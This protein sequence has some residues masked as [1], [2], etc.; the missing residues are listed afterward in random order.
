MAR[1]DNSGVDFSD[2][3]TRGL[4]SDLDYWE[5]GFKRGR[6]IQLKM[7]V[8]SARLFFNRVQTAGS[9]SRELHNWWD[10]SS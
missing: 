7:I 4:I 2:F 3:S 5:I 1:F 9:F 10:G 6:W 8:P